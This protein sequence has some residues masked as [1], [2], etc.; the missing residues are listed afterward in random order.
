MKLEVGKKY[1]TRDGV[2]VHIHN[3]AVGRPF[4]WE[5][6][7]VEGVGVMAGVGVTWTEDGRYWADTSVSSPYDLVARHPEEGPQWPS[8]RKLDEPARAFAHQL[9]LSG[10]CGVVEAIERARLIMLESE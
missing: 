9:V 10:A 7:V 1:L 3:Y 4:P 6:R 8:P 2:V 5:G